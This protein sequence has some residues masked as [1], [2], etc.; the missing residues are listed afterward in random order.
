[1]IYRNHVLNEIGIWIWVGFREGRSALLED[2][3]TP[4]YFRDDCYGPISP[5]ADPMTII[6][7]SA[8]PCT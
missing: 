5:P 6:D 2:F 1:M 4:S 3:V 8:L 7:I